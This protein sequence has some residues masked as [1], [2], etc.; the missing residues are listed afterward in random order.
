MVAGIT[1]VDIEALKSR[2]PLADAV[3]AAG[4]RLKGRGR[5]RQGVCPFHEEKEGSFTVYG[6]TERFY[7]FGCGEGGDV[8]DFVQR[9]EDLT[10]PEAIARL[11]G[12]PGLAPGAANRPAPR[13]PP[14]VAGLPPRDPNLL[15][16][17]ARFYAGQLRLDSEAQE[18][19]ASRGVGPAAAARL[20]LGY[21]PGSG[22][23][24]A[25]ESQGFSEKRVRDSGLFMAQGAERFAGTVVVPDPVSS[26]GQAVS[27]GLV[28]WLVGRAIDPDRTPRFQA[29]PGPRPAL[30][31]GR[32]GV[33]PPWVVVAEGVFDWLALAGWGLIAVAA[34]GTQG[35]DKVAEGLRGCPR[36]F[37]A[38]DAD[39]AG[40]EATE[41]LQSLLGRRAAAIT[42]PQGVG[43][44]AD[45][46]ALP[47]GRAAFLRLLWQ[48]ARSAR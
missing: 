3:E 26:T 46:A 24:Q 4:V 15:T 25:L 11:D 29:L 45:L 12:S 36:V 34:L 30:G 2:H 21:A 18:Y 8:L 5:V 13:Q 42:L 16:A 27:G 38:F 1:Q 19:L 17:A 7:C 47:H 44:V 6:D 9:M 14:E 40:R 37:L 23:R 35:V 22:L 33:A 28:R 32:L 41:R 39:D 43:D 31:L 10:L 48:A 20:G